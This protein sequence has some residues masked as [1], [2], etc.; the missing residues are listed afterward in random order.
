MKKCFVSQILPNAFISKAIYGAFN[1]LETSLLKSLHCICPF[2]NFYF[3]LIR[4]HSDNL[5]LFFPSIPLKISRRTIL[6]ENKG[7]MCFGFFYSALTCK[8]IHC[9]LKRY[10]LNGLHGSN[11][12]FPKITPQFP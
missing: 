1:L 12:S 8:E 10:W 7:E 6:D 5:A 11:I 3:C 2:L 9:F 4:R